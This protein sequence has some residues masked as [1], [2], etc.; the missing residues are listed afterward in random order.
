MIARLGEH[1]ARLATIDD[2]V[3]MYDVLAPYIVKRVGHSTAIARRKRILE[4]KIRYYT[5]NG[6]AVVVEKDDEITGV[7]LSDGNFV[8]HFVSRDTTS[9]HSVLVLLYAT[10]SVVHN[11]DK[12]SAFK[13]V[14][15]VGRNA[16][17]ISVVTI[18]E[19][20]TGFI[21]VHAKDVF[22]KRFKRLGGV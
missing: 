22:S 5:E 4:K 14:D 13:V 9:M 21:S 7:S 12:P 18:D 3:A 11:N 10:L 20:G 1:E 16:F 2:A 17:D 15:E 6:T 8:E 19:D